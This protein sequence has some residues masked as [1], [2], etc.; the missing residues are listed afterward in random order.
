MNILKSFLRTDYFIC[1]KT[2]IWLLKAYQVQTPDLG[3]LTLWI[4]AAA[5]SC[6]AVLPWSWRPCLGPSHPGRYAKG[7]AGMMRIA[8]QLDSNLLGTVSMWWMA[9]PGHLLPWQGMTATSLE[10]HL[11]DLSSAGGLK[12]RPVTQSKCPQN[13]PDRSCF[14]LSGRQRQK[15]YWELFVD[16]VPCW[17]LELT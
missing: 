3:P 1:L 2:H 11:Q 14:S 16:R 10:H 15:M 6:E 7:W 4:L 12:E 13:S 17:F 8:D 9:T 5:S